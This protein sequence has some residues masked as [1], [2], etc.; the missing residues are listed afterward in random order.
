MQLLTDTAQR[1][2][3]AF[4][5]TGTPRTM[6]SLPTRLMM[7]LK[8]AQVNATDSAVAVTTPYFY[9]D[10]ARHV[11]NETLSLQR[12]ESA[13]IVATF[14]HDWQ[15]RRIA[16]DALREHY[17]P[18]LSRTIDDRHLLEKLVTR[19]YI[20]ERERGAAWDLASIAKEFTVEL[21][22]VQRAAGMIAEHA[23][24]LEHAALQSLEARL[25][26]LALEVAHG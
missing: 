4:N 5:F 16:C 21:E 9:S 20:A 11:V 12:H 15:A 10:D 25:A 8:D 26:A 17:R 19:H 22:R 23:R 24:T 3:F 13:A 6:A 1:V 2:R 14:S 7:A 18:V